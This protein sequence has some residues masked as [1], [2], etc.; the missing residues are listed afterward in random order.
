MKIDAH[1]HF[2][3]YNTDEFGWIDESMQR[4]RRDF[5]PRD[6][7]EELQATGIDGVVSVQAR[8]SLEETEWLLSLAAENDFIKGVVGWVPLADPY[9]REHLARLSK[10]KKLKA[11]RHVVQAEPDDQFLSRKDFNLGI[12]AL[13]E[14]EFVYDILILER[15]LPQAIEFIDR[16]PEQIFVLDHAAKPRIKENLIDDWAR[17][18]CQLGRRPNVYCKISGMVTEAD[19]QTWTVEQLKPYWDMVL[20]AFGPERV[21]FGSDWPV[22]LVACEYARWYETVL[23][24][25]SYLSPS[26]QAQLFGETASRV[27]RLQE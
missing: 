10:N 1:H 19:S 25:A 15:Q 6:L 24:L 14:F 27:Y 21:M 11:V 3:R 23:D 16:H 13:A 18:M 26:E 9:I 7:V 4:I 2:W 22:C 12:A 20:A 17:Q 5:L 8:Q